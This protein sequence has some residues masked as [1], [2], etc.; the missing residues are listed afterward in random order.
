MQARPTATVSVKL[1]ENGDADQPVKY[2]WFDFFDAEDEFAPIVFPHLDV[3]FESGFDGTYTLNVPEGDYKLAIGAHNFGGLFRVTDESGSAT[4]STGT[5]DDGSVISLKVGETTDLGDVNMTSF[6]K[7]DAE[8]Y[9]FNWFDEGDSFSGSTVKGKVTTSNGI[10]VPKARII[11]HTTDYLFWFDHIQSRSD[12]SFELNDLPEGE[13]VIFAEPPFDSESFRSFRESG[14]L[15]VSLPDDA[16]NEGDN[17]LEVLELQESNVFGRILFPKKNQNG[18]TKNQGL[19]HAFV[20][21]FRDEDQDGEPDWEES[22]DLIEEFGETDENG[23]FSFYLE[24]AG[25]YSFIIDLPG[26]LSALSPEPIG[27]TLKNPSQ[28]TQ[29]GNAIRIDWKSD[30]RANSFD[31]Q[32]KLSSESSYVSLFTGENNDSK[33]GA[34]A[35]SFVDPSVKP[36][37]SYDYRVFAETDKG[38]IQIES[39]KIRISEPIIYLAPPSKTITGYVLDGNKTAIAGAEVV[40]W[41]EEGEGWSSTFTGDDGSYE[42]IAGPGKWEITVYRPYDD[43]VNWV[44]DGAPKRVKFAVGS[45][46]ES[47]SKNFTVSRMD[48]GMIT[49]KI[50][51]PAGVSAEDLSNYVYIDAFDP[52]GRGNWDQPKD[53]GTFEIPLQPGQY[54]LSLWIDPELKGFGSPDIK[55]VR[56]G[57]KDVDIGTLALTSRSKTISGVVKIANSETVLPNVHVWGWSEQ[58]GWVSDTTNING[59][60]SLAVSPGRWEVGFDLPANEDGSLPPYFVT[61][62]KR[63]RVKDKDKELDLYVQAAAATVSGVVYGPGGS[64]VSDLDAWVYAR[65]FKSIDDE[66]RDILAEVP[67]TSKGTFTFPGKPG[68]YLVGLWM[69]PGSDYGYAGEKYFK[70]E[71]D[72]QTGKTILK[73]ENGAEITQASFNLLRNDSVIK[74]SFILEG[75]TQGATGLTGEVY[76]VR[77]DGDG[78]QS[79]AIEDDGSYEMTLSAGKWA[80]DYYIESDLSDRKIPRYPSKPVIV[81]AEKSSSLT[82]DFELVSASMS[83]S[84]KVIYDSNKSAVKEHSLYVWAYRESYGKMDEYWNEVE[85]DENG[86]FS[87]PVL[88]G[89][90][91]EVGAILSQELRDQGYLDSLVVKANLSSGSVSDLNLTITKPS[92]ENFISG[93][94]KDPNGNTVVDAIVYAWS[95]D[96]REAY[97]ETDENGSYTLQVPNGVVWHVGAEYAEIDE[98]WF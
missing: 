85:T 25:E 6:G 63:L 51:L 40:A 13:W 1:L 30:V 86:A 48:G 57:K 49:G 54:E 31:I 15:F 88:P 91:Y 3:D 26:Q 2:A 4:W 28:A 45:K 24:E 8:L 11:A 5:W 44:Y 76:A 70:V 71:V 18:E 62:P 81:R 19:G 35:K 47:K 94:I 90:R 89:G 60:Y 61:P 16:Y 7:S 58:G 66:Y 34:R 78:W 46:K 29:L 65:E 80:L 39:S 33:P 84:G 59:E 27:F 50:K 67:L 93:T 36:G 96:G 52:E 83:I 56:V 53:D 32:R 14:E 74:G 43:N 20:W 82:Q 79:T 98:E 64:P 97:V 72:E 12:G 75:Q 69:P 41:R 92:S 23:Y 87:I 17:N 37:E 77:V 68:E 21:V 10:A 55:F 95:D 73:D 9:G 38:Q 42:L 22:S